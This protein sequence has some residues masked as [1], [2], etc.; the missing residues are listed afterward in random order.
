M[1][2]FHVGQELKVTSNRVFGVPVHFT[3]T[4]VGRKLLHGIFYYGM[5]EWKGAIRPERIWE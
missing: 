1:N 5:V 4:R 3:V 2:A